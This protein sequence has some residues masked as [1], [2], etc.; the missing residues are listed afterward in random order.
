[1]DE[2]CRINHNQYDTEHPTGQ[3]T[4]QATDQPEEGRKSPYLPFQLSYPS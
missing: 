2:Y 4:D 1:M 3:A